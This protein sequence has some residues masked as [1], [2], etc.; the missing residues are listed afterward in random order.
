MF[1]TPA[2]FFLHCYFLCLSRLLLEANVA[3]PLSIQS[4]FSFFTEASPPFLFI[5]ILFTDDPVRLSVRFGPFYLFRLLAVRNSSSSSRF[6]P[7]K[8][9]AAAKK[10]RKKE[11][12]LCRLSSSRD[13]EN[14]LTD[15]VY[16]SIKHNAIISLFVEKRERGE[17]LWSDDNSNRGKKNLY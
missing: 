6:E 1:Q 13:F 5:F 7:A 2:I 3:S 12:P 11:E 17:I 16:F 10:K 15:R 8:D 14:L 4:F 9:L